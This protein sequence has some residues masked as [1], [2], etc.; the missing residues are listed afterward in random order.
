MKGENNM[1]YYAIMHWN[2]PHVKALKTRQNTRLFEVVTK[3]SDRLFIS[4]DVLGVLKIGNII[5]EKDIFDDNI[6]WSKPL[7]LFVFDEKDIVEKNVIIPRK[8]NSKPLDNVEKYSVYEIVNQVVMPEKV[9]GLIL[10]DRSLN[11]DS[12]MIVP[13]DSIITV[14]ETSK[15]VITKEDKIKLLE[16]T[17]TTSII[18]AM[19]CL[20]DGVNL[21]DAK[22]N[23]DSIVDTENSDAEISFA[24]N[25]ENDYMYWPLLDENNFV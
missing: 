10:T 13:M 6:K 9:F 16:K 14:N 3:A 24:P 25:K 4:P 19:N 17:K 20:V 15:L 5:D 22:S 8:L 23:D 21:I 7:L 11:N 1:K 18:D 12:Y 2:E